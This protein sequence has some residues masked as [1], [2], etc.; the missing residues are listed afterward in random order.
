MEPSLEGNKFIHFSMM[1]FRCTQQICN[2]LSSVIV[3]WISECAAKVSSLEPAKDVKSKDGNLVFVAGATGKVGSRTVRLY[4]FFYNIDFRLYKSN[5]PAIKSVLLKDQ[6]V[7]R[8]LLKLGFK[9]RAGVR[10]AQ[11]AQPLVKVKVLTSGNISILL[12][13]VHLDPL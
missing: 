10:S 5:K 1:W 13:N 6:N 9:V 8:E 3:I 11:R 7:F 12:V 2:L 4:F